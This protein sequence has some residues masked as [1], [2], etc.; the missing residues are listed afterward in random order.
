MVLSPR[1][2][3]DDLAFG[4][5]QR[6]ATEYKDVLQQHVSIANEADQSSQ[7]VC[8]PLPA[9]RSSTRVSLPLDTELTLTGP[10]KIQS[11]L[12]SGFVHIDM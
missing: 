12:L 10:L 4:L 5:A 3:R 8:W 1:K 6:I 2:R 9:A 7:L 11:D